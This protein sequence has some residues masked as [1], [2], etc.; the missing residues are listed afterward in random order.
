MFQRAV[1]HLVE[2]FSYKF[3]VI[4]NKFV[5]ICRK[6]SP[7]LVY[8]SRFKDSDWTFSLNFSRSTPNKCT[9]AW[10][11]YVRSQWVLISSEIKF[12]EKQRHFTLK[13]SLW[14]LLKN[15]EASR[16]SNEKLFPYPSI[17]MQK[18]SSPWIFI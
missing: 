6:I 15:F 18:F 3:V 16:K 1:V 10:S 9:L 11:S 8:F 14:K 17:F 12:T 4:L 2:L 5:Q 13:S 7:Q